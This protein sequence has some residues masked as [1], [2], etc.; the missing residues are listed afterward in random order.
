VINATISR[1][2]WHVLNVAESAGGEGQAGNPH[3]NPGDLLKERERGVRNSA[4][5]DFAH[6]LWQ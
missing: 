4:V 5:A 1:P 2:S 6:A 3:P